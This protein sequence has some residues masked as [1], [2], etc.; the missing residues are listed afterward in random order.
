MSQWSSCVSPHPQGTSMGRGI[1]LHYHWTVY[2]II[3]FHLVR[4][5]ALKVL[6]PKPQGKSLRFAFVDAE[7]CKR[8]INSQLEH[9]GFQKTMDCR[10]SC[11][12]NIS[13]VVSVMFECHLVY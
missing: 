6:K 5:N 8:C 1:L 12:E 11:H 3:G 9:C 10:G 13:L 7:S 2:S 4:T